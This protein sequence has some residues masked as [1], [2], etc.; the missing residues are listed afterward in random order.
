MD[1]GT[2][3]PVQRQLI[4]DKRRRKPVSLVR[5]K[6]ATSQAAAEK[7]KAYV[8][9][10]RHRIFLAIRDA[11]ADGLTDAEIETVTRIHGNSVRPR[12]LSLEK[13]GYIRLKLD[14]A[15]VVTRSGYRVWVAVPG[16]RLETIEPKRKSV[17]EP[18]S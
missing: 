10:Q 12:R 1:R 18:K 6:V 3:T 15:E 4:S 13:S 2:K 8:G 16:K 17:S 9:R 14:R 5:G 11:G 7:I